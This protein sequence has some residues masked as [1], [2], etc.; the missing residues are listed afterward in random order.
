MTAPKITVLLGQVG[1]LLIGSLGLGLALHN[2]RRQL[3]AQMFIEFSKRFADLL[4]LFPTEAWL[5]NRQPRST[6]TTLQ[7]GTEGL[8]PLLHSIRRRWL[9]P[10]QRPF[11]IDQPVAPLGAGNQAYLGRSTILA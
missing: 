7:P 2:Q 11:H 1:T 5:A 4:S 8:H 9:L 10:S 6:A 3:D